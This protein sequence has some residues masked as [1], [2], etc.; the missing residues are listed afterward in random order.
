M[1]IIKT[2]R[3]HVAALEPQPGDVA[4]VTRI[5]AA[6]V[7]QPIQQY[8]SAV[9]ESAKLADHMRAH[10]DVVPIDAND[11]LSIGGQ[12]FGA[13]FRGLPAAVL[14]EL[15]QDCINACSEAVRYSDDADVRAQ[16]AAV[17]VKLGVV[18]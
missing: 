17:L 18:Q 11:L 9:H 16:A 3:N 7:V 1:S 13:M 6:R 15:R 5:G 12:S 2:K 10:V 14:E 8:A 4:V